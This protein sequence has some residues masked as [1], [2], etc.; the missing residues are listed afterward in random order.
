MK[1]KITVKI[2]IL[3]SNMRIFNSIHL[4]I[5]LTQ[6]QTVQGKID[7]SVAAITVLY[8]VIQCI[9]D[10]GGSIYDSSNMLVL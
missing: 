3:F 9:H 5:L 1:V 2:S 6:R 8:R 10:T 4:I 7:G